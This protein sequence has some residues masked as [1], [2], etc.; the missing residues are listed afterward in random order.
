MPLVLVENIVGKLSLINSFP[1]TK[2]R[3][4]QYP[5]SVLVGWPCLA[6]SLEHCKQICKSAVPLWDDGHEVSRARNENKTMDG[7]WGRGEGRPEPGRKS[8]NLHLF[9]TGT[10]FSLSAPSSLQLQQ[11]DNRLRT[12]PGNRNH[13]CTCPG[14]REAEGGISRDAGWAGSRAAAGV[15]H[16]MSQHI[17]SKP[18]LITLANFTL[19]SVSASFVYLGNCSWRKTNSRDWINNWKRRWRLAHPPLGKALSW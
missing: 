5:N 18:D 11:W 4:I 16:E 2:N 7:K 3:I 19:L 9:L 17:P 1:N 15:H 13:S 10:H 6:G 8:W 12:G 14:V